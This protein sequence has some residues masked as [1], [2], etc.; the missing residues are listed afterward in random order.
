M[1]AGRLDIAHPLQ[2][3]QR[4]QDTAGTVLCMLLGIHLGKSPET[5]DQNH[6]CG[7]RGGHQV[8]VCSTKSRHQVLRQGRCVTRIQGR[9]GR[10]RGRVRKVHCSLYKRTL[11]PAPS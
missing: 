7:A 3:G 10:G 9:K 1:K 6:F 11:P 5:S 2:P 8:C 4:L